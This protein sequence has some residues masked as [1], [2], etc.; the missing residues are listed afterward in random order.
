M[1]FDFDPLTVILMVAAALVMWKL[2]S[3]L[4][5]KTGFETKNES[6]PVRRPA[7]VASNVSTMGNSQKSPTDQPAETLPPVWQ[8]HAE[9]GSPSA[10]VFDQMAQSDPAF[11]VA[12]FINGAKQAYEMIIEAYARGDRKTL[13]PLLTT[14]TYDGFIKEIDRREKAGETVSLQFVGITGTTVHDVRLDR[15]LATISLRFASQMISATKDK[16]G[17][18]LSGD[19]MQLRDVIDVWSFERDMTARNPNWKLAATDELLE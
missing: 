8:G 4:G 6:D 5:T 1:N 11:T 16:T 12:L 3:V 13:K 7:D 15:N 2:K 9:P 19:A 17:Q 14:E 10:Q 18:I